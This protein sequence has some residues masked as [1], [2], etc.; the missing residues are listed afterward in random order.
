MLIEAAKGGH[1]AVA[2]LIMEQPLHPA[3]ASKHRVTKKGNVTTVASEMNSVG[4]QQPRK[5]KKS[6]CNSAH[7]CPII[8]HKDQHSR[9]ILI[10]IVAKIML[11]Y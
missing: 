9:V 2:C 7:K 1:T 6:V 11:A 4:V 8:P 10:E 3:R 5:P